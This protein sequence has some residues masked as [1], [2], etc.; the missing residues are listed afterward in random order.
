MSSS[1]GLVRRGLGALG[2]L[3]IVVSATGLVAGGYLLGQRLERRADAVAPTPS[4]VP[5]PATPGA[6]GGGPAIASGPTARLL[7]AGDI[8]SCA[9]LQDDRTSDLVL[10]IPGIVF[11]TG[12][13][14][15]NRGTA[16]RVPEVLRPDLGAVP[17]SDPA[18]P[19]QPRRPDEQG[20]PVL[21]L[22]RGGGRDGS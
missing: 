13:N 9:S 3:L 11:T 21:R 1:R 4:A 12:D 5:A 10:A 8:S 2:A 15:Y 22:L 18:G 19:R 6:S 17:R 14:A 20:C 16:R 7:G